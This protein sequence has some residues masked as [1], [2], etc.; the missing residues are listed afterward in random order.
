[1]VTQSVTRLKSV[2]YPPMHSV[3]ITVPGE[4]CMLAG[5]VTASVGAGVAAAVGIAVGSEVGELV[6]VIRAS[7]STLSS[8][9]W[10]KSAPRSIPSERPPASDSNSAAHTMPPLMSEGVVGRRVP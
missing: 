6:F 7:I 2:M 4:C 1:M 10:A 8:A 5:S 9:E 3:G